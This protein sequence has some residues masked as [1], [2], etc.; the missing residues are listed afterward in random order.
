MSYIKFQ[1]TIAVSVTKSNTAI[2]SPPGTTGLGGAIL[3][4]GISGDLKVTTEAGNDMV[5]KGVPVGFFPVTVSK[6][7]N[8]G[9]AEAITNGS[10]IALW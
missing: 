2:L 7:W 1:P 9:T 5:F 10:I 6:V 8:T 3:W 4:V